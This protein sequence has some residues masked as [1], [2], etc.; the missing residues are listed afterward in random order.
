MPRPHLEGL[1]VVRG[2]VELL[3]PRLLLAAAPRFITPLA[4]VP[5][6][7]WAIANYVDR[8]AS[9]AVLDY[10]GGDITYDGHAGVDFALPNFAAMDRGVPVYAAAAGTVIAV[11]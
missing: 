5:N 4:G 2:L 6:V 7:D 11:H 10:R 1:P 8:D 3:E 9:P